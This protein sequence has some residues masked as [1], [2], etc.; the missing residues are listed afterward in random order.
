MKPTPSSNLCSR[1]AL[2]RHR[3]PFPHSGVL[4]TQQ[5]PLATP[6]PG[7]TKTG[8]NRRPAFFVPSA[9]ACVLRPSRAQAAPNKSWQTI[10]PHPTLG[11]AASYRLIGTMHSEGRVEA[12]PAGPKRSTNSRAQFLSLTSASVGDLRP[13]LSACSSA[14]MLVL[15]RGRGSGGRGGRGQRD[16]CKR[17]RFCASK[18]DRV[19]PG[20]GRAYCFPSLSSIRCRPRRETG[21]RATTTRVSL[22]THT[23]LSSCPRPPTTAAA[24]RP[25]WRPSWA[26]TT[27]AQRLR[28]SSRLAMTQGERERGE[29]RRRAPARRRRFCRCHLPPP[30]QPHLQT[31]PHRRSTSHHIH[32]PPPRHH[33]RPVRRV[34]RRGDGARPRGGG[35][36]A[37]GRRRRGAAVSGCVWVEGWCRSWS[38]GN[39]MRREGCHPVFFR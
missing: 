1:V 16:N 19:A 11:V 7:P 39:R 13:L 22:H 3:L 24:W 2:C 36:R 5:C 30:Y 15:F 35:G 21:A 23:R 18:N 10:P 17:V 12:R 27:M 14:A 6:T 32:L 4:T 34:R 31:R 20:R 9:P 28:S 25:P 37:R 8:T 26:A 33:G 29:G 38:Q